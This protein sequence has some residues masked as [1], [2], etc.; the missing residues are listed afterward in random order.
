MNN[1][2]RKDTTCV[3]C[4]KDMIY[5]EGNLLIC[6]YCGTTIT[7]QRESD[8]DKPTYSQLKELWK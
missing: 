1:D 7:S 3:S 4:K 6:S 5:K 8:K 2:R